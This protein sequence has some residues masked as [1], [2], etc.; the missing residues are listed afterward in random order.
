MNLDLGIW[1]SGDPRVIANV[2]TMV[3]ARL[4]ELIFGAEEKKVNGH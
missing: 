2:E 4:E 1:M 3:Q